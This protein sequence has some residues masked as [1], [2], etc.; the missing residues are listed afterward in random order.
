VKEKRR[1]WQWGL[2]MP[3]ESN[4]LIARLTF[5]RFAPALENFVL[6]TLMQERSSTGSCIDAR[7][8]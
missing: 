8:A 4:H 2:W 3:D 6:L 1:F 5:R 7:S